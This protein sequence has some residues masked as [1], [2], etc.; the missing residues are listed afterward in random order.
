MSWKRKN[1]LACI[2][3]LGSM[4]ND[5]MRTYGKYQKAKDLWTT[6][7]EKFGEVSLTKLRQLTIKFDTF[8]K[9]SD[10]SMKQHLWDMS[11]MISELSEVGHDLTE[12]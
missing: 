5:L 12:K 4:E 9:H 6:L 10:H 11:N 7:I 3:M 8:K 1:S 2:T